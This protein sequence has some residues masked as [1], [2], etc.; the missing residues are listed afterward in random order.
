MELTDTQFAVEM[1]QQVF[2]FIELS[3]MYE[4]TPSPL[5]FA[6]H[7]IESYTE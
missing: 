6:Q 1:E 4:T 7:L 2:S 3:A 5:A